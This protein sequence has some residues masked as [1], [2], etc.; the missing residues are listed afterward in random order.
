MLTTTTAKQP[1]S[2]KAL[3]AANRAAGRLQ[4]PEPKEPGQKMQLVG[5]RLQPG[6]FAQAK[7][8]ADA[9]GR[10]MASFCRRMYLRGLEAHL[11][12]TGA[13]APAQ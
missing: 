10:S 3:V 5:M 6:E 2:F 4:P 1:T 8:M 11:S 9:D 13:Q 12:E 7:E